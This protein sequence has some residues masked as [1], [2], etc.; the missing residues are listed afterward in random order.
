[1]AKAKKM[2]L[3]KFTCS[4][5]SSF[6][7]KKIIFVPKKRKNTAKLDINWIIANFLQFLIFLRDKND[8]FLNKENSEHENVFKHIFFA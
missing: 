6:Y 2:R 8:F 4:E 7:K 3:N 5:F 1:M